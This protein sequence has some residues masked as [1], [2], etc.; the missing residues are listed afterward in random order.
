MGTRVGPKPGGGVYDVGVIMAPETTHM[1]VP[2]TAKSP[3]SCSVRHWAA[4]GAA[5]RIA[6]RAEL[7]MTAL[8]ICMDF[9]FLEVREN[10]L[11]VIW[12]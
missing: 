8:T 7:P 4:A 5:T 2:V 3:L 6:E 12:R 10:R 9:S 11:Q 1:L